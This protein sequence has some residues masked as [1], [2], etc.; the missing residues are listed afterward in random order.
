VHRGLNHVGEKLRVVGIDRTRVDRDVDDLARAVRLHGDHPA[1]G[2]CLDDLFRRVFLRFREL[3]LHALGLAEHLVHVELHSEG[4]SLI[5]SASRVS[6]RREI[7]SS[8]ESGTSSACS[9]GVSDS[10]VSRTTAS[11]LPVTS[12]KASL[13]RPMLVGSPIWR[14][15]KSAPAGNSSVRV[16]PASSVGVA[17]SSRLATGIERS[18]TASTMLRCQASATCSSSR[19]GPEA[20]SSSAGGAADALGFGFG[21]GGCAG[22]GSSILVA[23]ATPPDTRPSRT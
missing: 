16:S 11:F 9:A 23:W 3:L 8:S 21:V 14:R 7:T 1:A 2:S 20:S 13:R 15:W 12:Y 17:S 6:L 18:R 10:P 4:S 19:P 5:S 22:V